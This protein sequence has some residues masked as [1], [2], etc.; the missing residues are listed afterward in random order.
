MKQ[1]AR[2]SCKGLKMTVPSS[3]VSPSPSPSVG[4]SL[5]KLGPGKMEGWVEDVF[6]TL[7][8][9]SSVLLWFD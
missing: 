1:A 4:S 8:F 6:K 9:V 7:L 5:V 3:C 2:T